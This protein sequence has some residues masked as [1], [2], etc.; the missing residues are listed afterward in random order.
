MKIL[1]FLLLLLFPNILISQT[2]NNAWVFGAFNHVEFNPMI[3]DMGLSSM[4][5]VEGCTSLGDVNGDLVFYTNG[6]QVWNRVHLQMP[7]GFGLLGN[8]STAQSAVIVKLPMSGSLF[9]IFTV[10]EAALNNGL[11]YSIADMSLNGGLGDIIL[12]NQLIETSTTEKI[13][14]CTHSNGVDKWIITHQRGNNV[15]RADLLTSTGLTTTVYSSVGLVV[16]NSLGCL[17]TS[18]NRN[19]IASSYYGQNRFCIYD[20]DNNTGIISN[21]VNLPCNTGPYGVEFSP[22]GSKLYLTHNNGSNIYQYDL[23][24]SNLRTAILTNIGVLVGS[25]QL[26]TDGRIYFSQSLKKYLHVILN[27]DIPGIAC[28]PV[29]N[30]FGISGDT[31]FGLPN[32]ENACP[33]PIVPDYTYDLN[34][35]NFDGLA[36]PIPC[37]Y[38]IRGYRWFV[39]S[40]FHGNSNTL[41]L[42]LNNNTTY[43]I[44]LYI[45]FE[46]YTYSSIKIITP[47]EIN[48]ELY[49]N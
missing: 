20:F 16:N 23:C 33:Q 9:Y 49:Q 29:L 46:C 21:E 2:E 27:P 12:K 17:K 48:I 4:S 19:K 1:I 36:P 7:N 15:F 18:P 39:N 30:F 38:P 26:A 41:S 28:N 35:D 10:S 37:N 47:D 42:N 43:T 5:T 45:D 31:R 22:N 34:C 8:S 40:I 6:V 25:M 11:N 44:I 14:V 3:T 32:L 24:N 13:T